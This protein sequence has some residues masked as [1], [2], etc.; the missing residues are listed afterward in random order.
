MRL[1]RLQWK[2]ML[3]CRVGESSNRSLHRTACREGAQGDKT[4]GCPD[5]GKGH[6]SAGEIPL[7]A[8]G[9]VALCW[10]IGGVLSTSMVR[11]VLICGRR[12]RPVRIRQAGPA[13]YRVPFL[14][15]AFQCLELS[16]NVSTRYLRLR[17]LST[18]RDEWP[19]KLTVS[20]ALSCD[21]IGSWRDQRAVTFES[22]PTVAALAVCTSSHNY[23]C[24]AR[25]RE[26]G[27]MTKQTRTGPG[28]YT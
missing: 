17:V 21:C 12:E 3:D 25:R 6:L 8:G 5:E 28:R 26:S 27:I 15:V 20:V 24:M 4:P 13:V 11:I 2:P 22:D 14:N 10:R 9:E 23:G 1:P 18:L 16:M 7:F 19:F